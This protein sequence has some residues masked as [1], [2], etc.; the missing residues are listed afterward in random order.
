MVAC[1]L[2]GNVARR[3]M[4]I[5]QKIIDD[6]TVAL[7]HTKKDGT[8]NWQDGDDIDVCLAGTFAA[9]KF[10]TLINRSKEKK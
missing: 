8:E 3:M 5:T 4:K 6:L 10:I 7:A 2:I 1:R 9:D